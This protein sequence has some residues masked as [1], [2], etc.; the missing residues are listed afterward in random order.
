MCVIS[1]KT[2]WRGYTLIITYLTQKEREKQKHMA[3]RAQEETGKGKGKLTQIGYSKVIIDGAEWK[4]NK[5]TEQIHETNQLGSR[6][7]ANI[8]PGQ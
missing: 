4:W 3:M 1:N 5:N 6:S 7:G 8:E 2:D